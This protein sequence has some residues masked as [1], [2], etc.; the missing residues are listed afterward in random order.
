MLSQRRLVLAAALL[1]AAALAPLPSLAQG[2]YAA[3]PVTVVVSYPPGGDTD[4]GIPRPGR[5]AYCRS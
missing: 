4:A 5:H 1:G 3:K 2:A